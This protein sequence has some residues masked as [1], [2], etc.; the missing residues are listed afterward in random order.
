I[1]FAR[2]SPPGSAQVYYAGLQS[3][4]HRYET[5]TSEKERPHSEKPKRFTPPREGSAGVVES[6]PQELPPDVVRCYDNGDSDDRPAPGSSRNVLARFR[7]IEQQNG[8]HQPP[9][10]EAEARPR[11]RNCASES[12]AS[13]EAERESAPAASS[14]LDGL[15]QV[16]AARSLLDLWR[17]RESQ[18]A[19]AAQFQ[20]SRISSM[21]EKALEEETKRPRQNRIDPHNKDQQLA[22]MLACAV[23]NKDQQ[24]AE[25]LACAVQNKDQQLAEMLACAVQNK[26]QQLAEMLACAVQNKDQ[27]LAEMLGVRFR[28]KTSSWLR[29]L[30]VRFRTKTAAGSSARSKSPLFSRVTSEPRMPPAVCRDQFRIC[31]RVCNPES[32]NESNFKLRTPTQQE[33]QSF[34]S[35]SATAVYEN[36]PAPLPDGVVRYG[37]SATDGA[38]DQL[39]QQYTKRL[40]EKF[41]LESQQ[42]KTVERPPIRLDE[43]EGGIYENE[44]VQLPDVDYRLYAEGKCATL[45]K[46]RFMSEAAQKAASAERRVVLELANDSG[47]YENCPE[48]RDDVARWGAQDEAAA[49]DPAGAYS[50]RTPGSRPGSQ[51]QPAAPKPLDFDPQTGEFVG[52]GARAARQQYERSLSNSSAPK[53]KA[54]VALEMGEGGVYENQPQKLLPDVVQYQA[55]G[56]GELGDIRGTASAAKRQ[57]LPPTARGGGGRQSRPGLECGVFENDPQQRPADLILDSGRSDD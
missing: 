30:R 2:S 41:L 29:C 33:I 13:D 27:Q 52:R 18:A 53:P 38:Q 4:R 32:A 19:A 34:A 6:Q 7:E 21:W 11:S 44:P 48:V 23:Q 57:L 50:A 31:H 9:A 16:S 45:A 40:K 28:T 8:S 51:Q 26:D 36:E 43:G 37:Q 1:A 5:A 24:L 46:Q 17:R 3:A 47:V 25:M 39:E 55:G 49:F 56:G 20:G 12:S 14:C 22:E 42:Q 54:P 35:Q 15:P 10:K